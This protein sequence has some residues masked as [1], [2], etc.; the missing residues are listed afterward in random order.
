MMPIP[1]GTSAYKPP[2]Q[3]NRLTKNNSDLL[4][5]EDGKKK[6]EHVKCELLTKNNPLFLS[7]KNNSSSL[8]D[9]NITSPTLSSNRFLD[10]SKQSASLDK[11]SQ[12]IEKPNEEKVLNLFFAC[13]LDALDQNLAIQTGMLRAIDDIDDQVPILTTT[14]LLFAVHVVEEKKKEPLGQFFSKLGNQWEIY[15][16]KSCSLVLLLPKSYPLKLSSLGFTTSQWQK[17][18]LFFLI[19]SFTNKQATTIENLLELFNKKASVSRRIV[20]FGHGLYEKSIG[21]LSIENY[22]KLLVVFNEIK[23]DILSVRSCYAGGENRKE[24]TIKNN[25][26]KFPVLIESLG[27]YVSYIKKRENASAFFF[28]I[29]KA[30]KSYPSIKNPYL[31]KAIKNDTKFLETF[32]QIK[33]P[34]S[35][36]ILEHFRFL[37]EKGRNYSINYISIKQEKLRKLLRNLKVKKVNVSLSVVDREIINFIP[38]LIKATLLLEKTNG[39]IL[40]PIFHSATADT[41]HHFISKLSSS[42]IGFFELFKRNKVFYKNSATSLQKAFFIAEASFGHFQAKQVVL[43]YTKK[44]SSCHY[45]V[46]MAAKEEYFYYSYNEKNALLHKKLSFEEFVFEIEMIRLLTKPSKSSLEDSSYSGETVAL[47]KQKIDKLFWKRKF[48]PD[49]SSYLFYNTLPLKE[50]EDSKT[51]VALIRSI[52]PSTHQSLLKIALLTRN[53]PL[54]E[55]IVALSKSINIRGSVSLLSI[56][57]WNNHPSIVKTILTKGCF[58]EGEKRSHFPLEQAILLGQNDII[59]FILSKTELIQG[60]HALFYITEKALLKKVLEKININIDTLLDQRTALSYAI[61]QGRYELAEVLIQA[62][63]N[64]NMG[65]PSAIKQAVIKSHIPTVALLLDKKAVVDEEL[66]LASVTSQEMAEYLLKKIAWPEKVLSKS[67]VKAFHFYLLDVGLLFFKNGANLL[68][69]HTL[70]T[71]IAYFPVALFYPFFSYLVDA[72]DKR[73]QLPLKEMIDILLFFN[74]QKEAFI[75]QKKYKLFIAPKLAVDPSWT[76]FEDHIYAEKFIEKLL[77]RLDD[78]I[79]YQWEKKIIQ[80]SDASILNI[81]LHKLSVDTPTLH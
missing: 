27:P 60:G 41:A 17:T 13:D 48:P 19:K 58:L 79:V 75:F 45:A 46:Q 78:A 73:E 61:L 38:Q 69:M 59:D 71:S 56:A 31:K 29:G 50:K 36:P 6:L 21:G 68:S 63:A 30:V 11:N 54:A 10:L 5:K 42:T 14:T 39:R 77:L 33:F 9:R 24:Q 26:I 66:L 28:Y 64:P 43:N 15:S 8:N 37:Q 47:V 23:I 72:T 1:S 20:L 76:P 81:W 80:D 74:K 35:F 49:F 67:M 12:K 40:P 4:K 3:N 62:G 55:T 53:R 25:S 70:A 18:S 52:D 51:I 2:A 57:F 7:N 16:H 32:P 44:F 65:T 22:R 34:S